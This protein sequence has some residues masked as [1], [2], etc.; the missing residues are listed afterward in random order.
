LPH[1]VEQKSEWSGDAECTIHKQALAP[2]AVLT[3]CYCSCPELPSE[4]EGRQMMTEVHI[5]HLPLVALVNE[6]SG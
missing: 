1:P 6:V 5:N 2:S 4:W 3:N